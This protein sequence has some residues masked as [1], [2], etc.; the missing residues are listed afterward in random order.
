MSPPSRLA[1]SSVYIRSKIFD[2]IGFDLLMGAFRI[3][4]HFDQI[5]P[6]VSANFEEAV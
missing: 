3:L 1:F 5:Q 6:F 4:S 2:G